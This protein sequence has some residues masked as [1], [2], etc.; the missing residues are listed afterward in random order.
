MTYHLVHG[1]S[2]V[3]QPDDFYTIT[4]IS[5]WNR[6][7]PESRQSNLDHISVEYWSWPSR[8]MTPKWRTVVTCRAI[9]QTLVGAPYDVE[10]EDGRSLFLSIIRIFQYI[11]RLALLHR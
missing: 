4:A 1:D 11:P 6:E 2:L 9:L 5:D 8:L 7:F 3:H 10:E